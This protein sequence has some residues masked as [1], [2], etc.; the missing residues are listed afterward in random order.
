MERFNANG[1]A[2]EVGHVNSRF[3]TG[4]YITIVHEHI[5]TEMIDRQA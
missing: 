3:H 4:G 1:G 2:V 5:R